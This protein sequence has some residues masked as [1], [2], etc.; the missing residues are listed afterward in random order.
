MKMIRNLAL[1]VFTAALAISANAQQSSGITHGG[2]DYKIHQ[3]TEGSRKVLP[4]ETLF[5]NMRI[6]TEKADSVILE[7]FKANQPRYVPSSEPVLREAFAMLA[8]GDSAEFYINADSL[9]RKSFGTS[10][11]A[12]MANGERV[13]FIVRV[14]D[15]LNQKEM[16]QKQTDFVN[17][18]K[19]KDSLAF[20][21]YVADLKNVKTTPSG[22]RY[23]VTKKASGKQPQKGETVSMMYKGYLLNGQEFD[24]NMD[25]IKPAFEFKLG[26]GQVIAG[27]D[28]GVALMK[29]GEEFK[30][31]IP[32]SL[33]YGERGTG[34]IPAYSS[35]VFEVKLLKIK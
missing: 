4:G 29:E 9:F 19:L 32:W 23:V 1:C 21:K 15:I 24:G 14:V 6:S 28:E 34:P 8:K 18:L 13:K 25:G 17:E 33:A 22:L 10:K 26:Q 11:P 7:T 20:K 5:L 2:I 27:W 16:L 12:N 3:H 31:I 35:L 30:F